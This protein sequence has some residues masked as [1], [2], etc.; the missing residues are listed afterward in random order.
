[1]DWSRRF[2]AYAAEHR[3]DWKGGDAFRSFLSW[4]ALDRDVA[5]A[6]QNQAFN[7]LLFLHRDVLGLKPEEIRAVRAKRGP[8]LP[9]V[10]SVEEVQRV[11]QHAEG[12][13]RLMLQLIYG[14]GLRVSE[15]TRLRVQDLDFASPLLFVRA[16][17]GDKDRTTLLP[18]RLIASMQQQLVKVKAIHERDLAAGYGAVYL[19]GALAEKYPNA[20]REW[21]WQYVFPA[22]TLSIDPRGGRVRRHHI[23]DNVVQNAMRAAVIRSGIAKHATVHT[24]RHSFATHLLLKNVNIREV[25]QYLGHQSVETTMIYTHVIRGLD[26]TAESPLDLLE[27]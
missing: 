25:Q 9:V 8:K 6:T 12:I 26:S 3:L 10:L 14:A 1:V 19:P 2:F 15:L 20:P 4:L 27:R 21:G 11:L 23:G 7:A 5:A 18:R 17:K 22:A 16:A 24:L 13:G